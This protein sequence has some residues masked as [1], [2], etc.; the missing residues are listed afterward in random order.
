VRHVGVLQRLRAAPSVADLA[1]CIEALVIIALTWILLGWVP[2]EPITQADGTWLV[3]PY[4]SSS[5]HAGVDWTN[6]LYRF[7]VIG[8]SEM[9]PFGGTTPLVQLAS[10]LGLSATATLNATTMFL[11]LCFAVFGM[12]AAGAMSKV[13]HPPSAPERIVAVWLCG[14]APV[15]ASRLG[16]GHENLL[17]GLLPLVV[18]FSLLWCA[19]ANGLSITLL[20]LGA[21]A[22]TVG[23]SG[24]GPQT[25]IY[26]AVFGAPLVLATVLTAPRGARW[27]RPQWIVVATIAAAVLVMLPRLASMI[28]H[29]VGDDATRTLGASVVYAE[30]EARGADWLRSIPWVTSDAGHER[31][32]PIGALLLLCIALWPRAVSRRLGYAAIASLALAVAFASNLTPISTA[33]TELFPPLAAFRVPA[34]AVLPILTCIP[35]IAIAACWQFESELLARGQ[36]TRHWLAILGAVV[37]ILAVRYRVPW[38]RESVAWLACAAFAVVGLRRPQLCQR[39]TPLLALVA[40]LGVCAFYDR[41]PRGVPKDPIENGPRVLHAAVRP[42]LGSALERVEII[43]APAP[44]QMSTA[45]AARLPSLDGVWYP[46][47]RFLALLSAIQGKPLPPTTAVFALGK[48]RAFRLLQQLYNVTYAV[49]GLGTGQPSL[50]RLPETPGAAWFPAV[51]ET[52]EQPAPMI[53]ALRASTDLRASLHAKAWV[54]REDHTVPLTGCSDARV[55]GVTTDELEQR[56]E[57][58]TSVPS[59]CVLVVA[60]N[61]VSTLRATALVDGAAQP[62]RVFPINIALTG[63]AVPSRTTRVSL[64]PVA[65]IPAWTRLAQVL[66]LL[67]LVIGLA[68]SRSGRG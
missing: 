55:L 6:H 11:Q 45:F 44:Y 59:A 28:A 27:G 17:S 21:F 42:E 56:A 46:P 2:G 23:V 34:R 50:Q 41:I 38:L 68:R 62:A 8:G 19:R 39:L 48:S 47:R 31:N 4:T 32:Y 60:T 65:E 67:L 12:K 52:I 15:L 5:L 40:A 35:P 66:G 29:A 22:T 54:L 26:G 20:V 9:H 14:F 36:R 7:G 10:V 3:A 61:V 58:E 30:G 16:I 37:V 33:L 24:L 43:D 64:A 18:A 13:A 1:I 51:V 63:I 53:D 25:L 57:I 49:V